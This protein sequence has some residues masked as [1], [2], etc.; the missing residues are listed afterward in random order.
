MK[1]FTFTIISALALGLSQ[2][3]QAHEGQR[4]DIEL[5]SPSSVQAGLVTFDF[6]LIDEKNNIVLTDQDLAVVHEK[7]LHAFIFDAALK[8]FRHE[9]PEYKNAKWTFLSDLPVNGNYKVW[10]Q[11]EIASD[12][13]EFSTFTTITVKNGSTENP[14]PP[15]LGD[16]RTGTEGFSKVSLPNTKIVANKMTMLTAKFSRVDGSSPQITP[17]LG[18]LAHV[19]S[20]TSDGEA[21]VH[22]HPMSTG[23]PNELVIHTTFP[24]AGDYRLWVQFIDGNVLRVIP[25]SVTVFSKRVHNR[26][27]YL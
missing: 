2:F 7:K 27:K 3:A 9:H 15:V 24:K 11:G 12:N 18:E 23:T 8:E 10:I 26:R 6:Q 19:V 4:V 13:E 21:L 17:Y 25:L 5:E 20:T 14:L 16:I 1:H 22:V